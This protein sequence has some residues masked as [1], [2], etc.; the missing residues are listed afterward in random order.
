[1]YIHI[2]KQILSIL[3][4]FLMPVFHAQPAMDAYARYAFQQYARTGTVPTGVP[5]L[6][7]N[8]SK[9][10]SLIAT[11]NHQFSEQN[12]Q[13]TGIRIGSRIGHIVTLKVPIDKLQLISGISGI[14]Y[15]EI[16]QRIKPF[17][18]KARKDIRADSVHAGL[19]LP[20]AFQGK[21]VMIGITDWGFDYTHPFFYDTT[22]QHT[23]IYAAWDQFKTSGPAPSGFAYGTEYATES[24]L[25]AAKCDTSNIYGRHYHGTHVAGICA[26]NGNQTPYQGIAP[27]AHLLFVTFQVDAGAVL[28]AFQ[29]M[30]QKADEAGK[31]LVVNMSWGLY[32]M[33]PIDGS[34]L[35]SQALALYAAQN[36]V[37]VTSGG[38]N[39]DVNFH[40]K[41]QFAQ[42]SIK[43]RV[44]TYPFNLHEDL[45]GQ[46]L[47]AWGQPAH[48]FEAGVS[49]FDN[50][51]NEI[52]NTS[53]RSTNWN[54]FLDTLMISGNDTVHI[55]WTADAAHPL[56]Q[57]PHMRIRIQCKNT[58]NRIIL[59]AR[60]NSGTVHFW[61]ITD[62]YTDVGNW[63]MP[64]TNQGPGAFV[65]G[66]KN[67]G[68]GEPAC[69]PDAISV[70]AYLSEYT[71]G[72]STVYGG[73]LAGFSSSGPLITEV[74]KPDIAA[75]GVDIFSSINRFTDADVNISGYVI[76]QGAQYPYGKLSGTSMSAP[77][78]SGV[79][80]LM[81]D[82]F[83]DLTPAEVR[84]ILIETA[85]QDSKTGILP[86]T[87]STQ[88]GFGK[89]HAWKAV[90]RAFELMSIKNETSGNPWLVV[91]NPS[92]QNIRLQ[93]AT[94]KV[95]DLLILDADG[96]KIWESQHFDLNETIDIS[97]WESGIYIIRFKVKGK[98][99]VVRFVKP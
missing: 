82:A 18:E 53:M 80:A 10:I 67:Y 59:T 81:L 13:H 33:G 78:V 27:E 23:R 50:G 12:L 51:G 48:P 7:I 5:C 4:L 3:A 68:I 73:Q 16:A 62:L 93:G 25:L 20:T 39:G 55:I 79:V 66:D 57:R 64:F 38:N 95:E 74:V 97:N 26:G 2:M 45:F 36:V 85:R 98:T 40:I 87:G 37:F 61:N 34:S 31:R 14:T 56:N 76:F 28:D 96:R 42:D 65:N 19:G 11:V 24:D 47:I 35:V 29:W 72:T 49:I 21:D 86:D 83:P 70:A 92:W 22:L 43:T 44:E 46:S 8:G 88:W 90:Y 69:S 32:H 63:G 84:Q 91:P 71:L 15:I 75:P 1:M 17:L 94:E 58:S 41:K 6:N 77:I 99:S 60:A 54:G 52:L 89:V 9:Y 30:K